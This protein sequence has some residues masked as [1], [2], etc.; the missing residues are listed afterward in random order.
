[1]AA[2]APAAAETAN[3]WP[4]PA[5]T[6]AEAPAVAEAAAQPEAR[7]AAAVRTLSAPSPVLSRPQVAPARASRPTF[8][9]APISRVAAVSAR[10][11]RIG[12]GPGRFVVQLG[13]FTNPQNAERAWQQ[14]SARFGLGHAEQRT[15]RVTVNG[16]SFTRVAIAGFGSRADAA[17]VCSSIQARGGNCFVR[18]LAGDV[19]VRSASNPGR[20][21]RA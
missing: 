17:R 11:P 9:P 13:A 18:A 16:R 3:W 7:Y 8:R 12:S 20:G 14:A 2:P 6:A 1:V 4:S 19:P 15:A 21:R 10:I 5:R